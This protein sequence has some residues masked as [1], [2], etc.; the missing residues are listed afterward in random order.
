MQHEIIYVLT[1]G[2]AS[3]TPRFKL[4][5]IYSRIG[6]QGGVVYPL[7]RLDEIRSK[8]SQRLA[9]MG[10]VAPPQPTSRTKTERSRTPIPEIQAL[11]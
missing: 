2:M 11:I 4:S 5:Q 8:L 6:D 1:H 10:Q 3:H 7:E 9:S